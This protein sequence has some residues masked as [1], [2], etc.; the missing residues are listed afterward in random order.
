M[1][2]WG[3]PWQQEAGLNVRQWT[4]SNR[5]SWKIISEKT[6]PKMAEATKSQ[7]STFPSRRS[8]FLLALLVV[9]WRSKDSLKSS[10]VDGLCCISSLALGHTFLGISMLQKQKRLNQ[11]KSIFAWLKKEKAIWTFSI[12]LQITYHNYF[13]CRWNGPQ[14]E[15]WKLAGTILLALK[16]CSIDLLWFLWISVLPRIHY[17]SRLDSLI[18]CSFLP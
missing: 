3:S 11:I 9:D 13:H 12:T 14:Y 5:S 4:R 16:K 6:A 10:L 2:F 18:H 17:V 15:L 8:N 7:T 1:A